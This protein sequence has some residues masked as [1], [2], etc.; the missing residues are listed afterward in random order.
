MP[1]GRDL[2][3]HL[4]QLLAAAEWSPEADDVPVHT[5]ARGDV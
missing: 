3:E 1:E 5:G 4:R 2:D